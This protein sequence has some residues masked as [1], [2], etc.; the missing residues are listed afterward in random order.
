MLLA[1]QVRVRCVGASGA[2]HGAWSA[3][4]SVTLPADKEVQLSDRLTAPGGDND[5]TLQL[6]AG[7]GKLGNPVPKRRSAAPKRGAPKGVPILLK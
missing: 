4:A 2:G 3:A 7:G 1:E 5:A 6:T